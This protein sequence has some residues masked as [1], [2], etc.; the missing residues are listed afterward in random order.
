MFIKPEKQP[1]STSTKLSGES[2]AAN[3]L[4]F[5]SILRGVNIHDS[6]INELSDFR[7]AG[8]PANRQYRGVSDS[9][10]ITLHVFSKDAVHHTELNLNLI[11]TFNFRNDGT[12]TFQ[13]TG[14][15]RFAASIKSVGTYVGRSQ[16]LGFAIEEKSESTQLHVYAIHC[17]V[18]PMNVYAIH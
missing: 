16:S 3:W 10:G 11:G 6:T 9:K 2:T 8:L 12:T 4:T 5:E 14:S 1:K 17:D 13:F 15:G 7:A 18:Q